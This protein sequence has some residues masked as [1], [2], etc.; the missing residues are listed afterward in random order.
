[1]PTAEVMA[2]RVFKMPFLKGSSTVVPVQGAVSWLY[3]GLADERGIG[4]KKGFL[5]LTLEPWRNRSGILA[6]KLIRNCICVLA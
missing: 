6:R 1:M 3:V 5:E 2:R 4:A